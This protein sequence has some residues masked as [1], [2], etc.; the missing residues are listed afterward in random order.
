MNL[1]PIWA[2]FSA[3]AQ[4]Y[5]AFREDLRRQLRRHTIDVVTD[6]TRNPGA[7]KSPRSP[8]RASSAPQMGRSRAYALNP[9]LRRRTT[10]QE[11]FS[12]K[13]IQEEPDSLDANGT[14]SCLDG[15]RVAGASLWKALAGRST[16]AQ[17]GGSNAAAGTSGSIGTY[18]ATH[19]DS[20]FASSRLHAI[21]AAQLPS[22]LPTKLPEMFTMGAPT[23]QNG[24][25]PSARDHQARRRR[26]SEAAA[27]R[28]GVFSAISQKLLAEINGT[29][30][31]LQAPSDMKTPA[32]Q[33]RITQANHRVV[34]SV[35]SWQAVTAALDR[36]A[37]C[38][39]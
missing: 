20:L 11:C 16:A 2:D 38:A 14:P 22:K 27:A 3:V 31:A 5:G 15:V 7:R 26:A 4:R 1:D 36:Y 34:S 19:R 37:R 13:S 23:D 18:H 39:K 6:M 9:G 35:E 17:S 25:R 28:Q 21:S 24:D 32:D 8:P 12:G 33:L 29:L 10:A 30:A